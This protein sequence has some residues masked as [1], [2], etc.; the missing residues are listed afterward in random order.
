MAEQV[1][2]DSLAPR[3]TGVGG[4]LVSPRNRVHGTG[5]GGAERGGLA[6]AVERA[7][8]IIRDVGCEVATP[9]EARDMLQLKR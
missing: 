4:E 3:S 5:A 2:R 8:R 9:D 6:R 1:A 7:V